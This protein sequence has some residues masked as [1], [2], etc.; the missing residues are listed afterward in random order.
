[1]YIV[2]IKLHALAAAV[3]LLDIAVRRLLNS[4]KLIAKQTIL[5]LLVE[6]NQQSRFSW[7][8]GGEGVK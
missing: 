4:D 6:Q 1:M 3:E 7:T 8:H 2:A 5:I